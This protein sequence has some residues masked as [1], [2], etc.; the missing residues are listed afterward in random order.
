MPKIDC[1]ICGK[2]STTYKGAIF[3][4]MKVHGL[5]RDEAALR[6]GFVCLRCKEKPRSGQSEYCSAACGRKAAGE[7]IS[8]QRK[9]ESKEQQDSR[10]SAFYKTL[11][12]KRDRAI[13]PASVRGFV[14]DLGFQL[15]EEYKG[16]KSKLKLRCSNGHLFQRSLWELR[17]FPTCTVCNSLDRRYTVD[18]LME[19]LTSI[20]YTLQVPSHDGMGFVQKME[21]VKVTCNHGHTYTTPCVYVLREKQTCPLCNTSR[22]EVD[23]IQ[24]LRSHFTLQERCR[25]LIS[26]KEI[27]IVIPDHKVAVEVCG[28]Y[29]HSEAIRPD[30]NYHADKMRACNEAGY[31]LITLF[32]D[33]WHDRKEVCLSRILNACGLSKRIGARTLSV[34]EVSSKDALAFYE[35]N[36][37]QGKPNAVRASW[38]LYEGEELLTCLSLGSLTRAHTGSADVTELKR[39]ATKPGLSIPGG[40]ARLLKRAV[41]WSKDQNIS[42]IRSYCDLRWGTGNAYKTLGFHLASSGKPIYWYTDG[43]RRF[44]AFSKRK[45]V[46]ERKTGLTE[47][48]LRVQQGLFRIWDCGHQTWKL[49]VQKN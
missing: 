19:Q 5:T 26:P 23:V 38:G 12:A 20:G 9:Q 34:R 48:E 3:K 15:D 45:T 33:E 43:S 49:K 21:P 29:W 35:E 39:M 31:R 41:A 40:F 10:L 16:Q 13:S 28:L 30:P 37:L 14:Q 44:S 11:E 24:S 36:H 32:V 2:T 47:V 17:Q 1:P 27:D 6:C 46:E 25:S 22:E 7:K 8:K 4:H 42:E 18:R